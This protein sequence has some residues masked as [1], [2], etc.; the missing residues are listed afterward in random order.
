MAKL[1]SR[2][3]NKGQ[4]NGQTLNFPV[5][6]QATFSDKGVLEV[7]DDKVEALILLT[8]TSFDFIAEGSEEVK[9]KKDT[10]RKNKKGEEVV[11]ETA[12]D[13]ELKELLA[14]ADTKTLLEMAGEAQ[15][16]PASAASMTDAR[17]RQELFKVL[18]TPVK[19]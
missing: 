7:E 2:K 6:G 1:V 18:K 11:V 8:E 9:P 5:I 12:E 16:D 4:Y 3:Y 13:K 15:L 17:L 10:V 19:A 14:Q